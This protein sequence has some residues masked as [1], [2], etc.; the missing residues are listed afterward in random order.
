LRRRS[1]L[2]RSIPLRHPVRIV[3]VAD[4]VGREHG[5]PVQEAR[6]AA[7]FKLADLRQRRPKRALDDV[8]RVVVAAQRRGSELDP[9][10]A[11]EPVLVAADQF[12]EGCTVAAL[13]LGQQFERGGLGRQI[14]RGERAGEQVVGVR[15]GHGGRCHEN[16][17]AS[18]LSR[19]DQGGHRPLPSAVVRKTSVSE[20]QPARS[21]HQRPPTA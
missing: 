13:G 7:Q 11:L 6:R 20:H 15:S 8:H 18:R 1:D 19:G 14:A 3:D 21:P 9:H 5:Q 16:G 10:D 4:L 2:S 17:S 12:L